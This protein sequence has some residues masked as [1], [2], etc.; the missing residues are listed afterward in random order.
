MRTV[1]DAMALMFQR[2][3]ANMSTEELDGLA[4]LSDY[5]ADEAR[6]LSVVCEGLGC[7]IDYDSRN[8][9]GAGN[10]RDGDDP[11]RN[12]RPPPQGGRLIALSEAELDAMHGAGPLAVS[13]YLELRRM[14]D[15]H[16]GTVGRSTPI[17]LHGL[18]RAT[19]THITRGKGFEI[20]QPSEKE[21][22]TGLDRLARAGL[23]RRLPGDRLAYRLP[24]AL[25][26]R[27]RPAHTGQGAGTDSSTQPGT[28]DTAPLQAMPAEQGTPTETSTEPNRAH[29]DGQENQNP[30][31]SPP[32]A[33]DNPAGG[34]RRPN[35]SAAG[36][37]R[38]A[39]PRTAC[40]DG[41][42]H[43]LLLI[44]ARLGITARPG[45]SW[46]DYGT[47]VAQARAGAQARRSAAA[48]A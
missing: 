33:V 6:R 17:S 28:A 22:R 5:A 45:E 44:G 39:T 25:T 32:P 2:G 27:A 24:L 31:A 16:D 19:E 12:G 14:M 36:T 26:A 21:I 29:I 13:L 11:T 46:R 8:P 23:L 30:G 48:Y 1:Q 4:S 47:R 38:T 41:E 40:S 43:R 18:A 15:Y 37:G 7:L 20:R 35:R 34:T 42:D 10:F 9:T 3:K